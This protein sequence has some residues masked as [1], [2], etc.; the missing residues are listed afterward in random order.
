MR[1]WKS[2]CRRRRPCSFLPSGA[3]NRPRPA[4]AQFDAAAEFA[5][6]TAA[7]AE[8]VSARER[9][10]RAQAS[11]PPGTQEGTPPS[12]A[13]RV[14]FDAAYARDQQLLAA[15]LNRGAQPRAR[16]GPRRAEALALYADAAPSN[17]APSSSARG[18]DAQRALE[19]ST[20]R[21]APTAAL[22]IP[23]PQASPRRW[24][25]GQAP[26]GATAT[27]HRGRSGA[28]GR[29]GVATAD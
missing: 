29:T 24:N 11:A 16:P 5:R 22:G 6:V 19:P 26:S 12:C 1:T 15:F 21:S 2:T 8:F 28:A 4:S 3:A 18:G 7:H 25:G 20:P 23:V 10:D 14:G 27:P 9:L 17:A 13:G